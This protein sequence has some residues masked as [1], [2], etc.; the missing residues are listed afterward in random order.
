MIRPG[1]PAPCSVWHP[2]QTPSVWGVFISRTR[3][4]S[5]TIARYGIGIEV[6]RTKLPAALTG[7][8]WLT[9]SASMTSTLRVGFESPWQSSGSWSVG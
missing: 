3:L 6:T 5:T 9:P 1:A 4:P 8:V 2:L 7:M